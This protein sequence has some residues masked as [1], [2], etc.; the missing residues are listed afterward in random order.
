MNGL[1][2]RSLHPLLQILLL[3]GLAL[4]G[5]CLASLLALVLAS[6]VFGLSLAQFGEL[7]TTPER[8]PHGWAVS[9]LLQGLSLAGLGAGAAVLPL[10]LRAPKQPA[11]RYFAPRPLRQVWWLGAAGLL[12]LVSAPMQSALVAWNA[13]A[14][15]P[16]FL[17][18]F[19][20]WAR[21][22]ENQA[23]ELTKFLT[24]FTSPAR[25]LVA[26]LVIA[27]I[28]A[29][30]E[31][32]VF[33]GVI[34]R[35]LVRWFNSKHVGVWLTAALFSAVHLQFFG[36]VPRFLLGLI[37]GYLYEWSGNILVPMAAHFTQ[38]AFQLL[39]LYLAQGRHLP[40][41]FDPDANQT[42]PWP[43]VLLSTVL[44]AALLYTLHQRMVAAAPPLAPADSSAPLR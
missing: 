22:K 3:M 9:M 7:G 35:N 20:Q 42:L 21:D 16:A 15:F 44:S 24:E 12:I 14:H 8:V 36:F 6:S 26:L 28:P 10:V 33:R 19:E 30:A 4:A 11:E 25:L 29:I 32:L 43:V 38:N 1:P 18:D 2:S 39:L 40:S 5:L 41:S 31:E 13:D 17:R 37:L 27:V 34:Q 23:A